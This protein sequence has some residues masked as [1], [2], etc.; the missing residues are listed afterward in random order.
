LIGQILKTSCLAES[1]F[2]KDYELV[3]NLLHH[4]NSRTFVLEKEVPVDPAHVGVVGGSSAHSVRVTLAEEAE[5]ALQG[6]DH[7]VRGAFQ[8]AL[9]LFK[10]RLNNRLPGVAP[11]FRKE[12]TEAIERLV[13]C[14]SFLDK[15]ISTFQLEYKQEQKSIAS[16]KVRENIFCELL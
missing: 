9:A 11:Q 6:L 10:R 2:E 7:S 13:D 16:A 14:D 1:H 8:R 15:R 5:T 4:L 3:D 12:L